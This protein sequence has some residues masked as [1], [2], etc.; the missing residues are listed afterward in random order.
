MS[1]SVF[2]IGDKHDFKNTASL[3]NQILLHICKTK[4]ADYKT[5]SKET[6]RDRITILQ[7]L[8][9]LMK[10]HLVTKEKVEPDR[11]KSKLI[12]RPTLKGM[13]YS[14]A[15]LGA[16][17]DHIRK[18]H[19]EAAKQLTNHYEFVNF[20]NDPKHR[21]RIMGHM[22]R[23]LVEKDFFD[24]KGEKIITRGKSNMLKESF[25]AALFELTE[26]KDYN[27]E[28]VF[29]SESIKSITREESKELRE[30]FKYV[31]LNLD[32]TIEH[33]DSISKKY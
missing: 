15:F 12:F 21:D 18:A 28:S 2:A 8:Q 24:E 9:S 17:Y 27:C 29:N 3:Q 26:N 30:F 6:D 4:N 16:T 25:R 31:R 10:R 32:L 5:I 13:A 23:I 7:S 20:I 22:T 19:S 11:I 1:A 14:I 33:L